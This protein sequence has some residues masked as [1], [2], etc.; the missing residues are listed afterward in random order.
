MQTSPDT[1][2]SPPATPAPEVADV[3]RRFADAWAAPAVDRFVELLHPEVHLYQPI[4]AP[5]IGRE[6]ARVE[7]ARLLRLLPDL[8]GCVDHWAADGDFL[9]I[10]WRLRATWG[11]KAPYEWPIADHIRVRDGLIAERRALFDPLGVFGAMLR[12]GPR[13]WLAYARYRGYLPGG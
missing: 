13:S 5:I 11:G 10:A 7:F 3:A 1:Q 6:A 4:T 9:L 2:L 12:G 8:R